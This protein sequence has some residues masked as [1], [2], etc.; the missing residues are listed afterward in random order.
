VL[1]NAL[2]YKVLT[3]NGEKETIGLYEKTR[4]EIDLVILDTIMPDMIMDPGIDG[5][6]TYKKISKFTLGR[7]R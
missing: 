2:G 5:L 6:D 4:D 3:A 1:L 7:R